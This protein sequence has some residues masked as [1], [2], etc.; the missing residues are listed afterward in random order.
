MKKNRRI[1]RALCRAVT[2]HNV[3]KW[4]LVF[5]RDYIRY[6]KSMRRKNPDVPESYYWDELK[7][8]LISEIKARQAEG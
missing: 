4:V 7:D 6:I 5:L 2:G 1:T 3:S 8:F